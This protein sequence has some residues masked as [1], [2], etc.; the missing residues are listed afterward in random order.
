MFV[1]THAL[2]PVL[3]AQCVQAASL[4]TRQRLLFTEPR[5]IVAIGIAGAAPDLLSPHLS[6]A[7]RY[8]SWTHNVW[9]LLAVIPVIFLLARLFDPMSRRLTC[10]CMWL[11]VALHLATDAC[12]N[13]INWLYPLRH[14]I[15]G[16]TLIPYRLWIWSELVFLIV[17]P[18]TALVLRKLHF[19]A[20]DGG[21]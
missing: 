17:V 13:G 1:V 16:T 3:T 10:V 19:R 7:A 20:A 9:F 18:I 4:A 12:S 6:L 5:S 21:T 14:E 11:A 8:A 2:L 15:L